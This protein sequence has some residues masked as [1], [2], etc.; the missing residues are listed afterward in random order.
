M[1]FAVPISVNYYAAAIGTFSTDSLECLFSLCVY[2][3]H[4]NFILLRVDIQNIES[5]AFPLKPP[6]EYFGHDLQFSLK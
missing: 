6:V 2:C 1:C 5:H 4:S 3:F